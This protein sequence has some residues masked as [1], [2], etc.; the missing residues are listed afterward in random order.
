[1]IMKFILPKGY[2]S[3]NAPRPNNEDVQVTTAAEKKLATLS[4]S[5]FA[6]RRI[7]D[8]KYREL[9]RVLQEN[10]IATKGEPMLMQYNDPW[11]PPFMRRNEVAIEVILE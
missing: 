6:T 7:T 9:E 1:M 8:K 3:E 11:T 2:T 5:G 4:F 10:Q